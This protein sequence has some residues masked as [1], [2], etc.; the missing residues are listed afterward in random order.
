MSKRRDQL[1]L[2]T[3]PQYCGES[4]RRRIQGVLSRSRKKEKFLL[5]DRGT[6]EQNSCGSHENLLNISL[7]NNSDPHPDQ[8]QT[9]LL[10]KSTS[11]AIDTYRP[12]SPQPKKTL[13]RASF[14]SMNKSQ[15]GS[16]HQQHR[17]CTLNLSGNLPMKMRRHSRHPPRKNLPTLGDKLFQD[18][19][20]FIVEG[21]KGDIRST[22]KHRAIGLPKVSPTLRS[23]WLHKIAGL[24]ITWFPDEACGASNLGCIFSSPA[25]SGCSG[26]SCCASICNA[27]RVFLRLSPRCIR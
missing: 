17:P 5:I 27:R 11:F 8:A 19:R 7:T 9:R 1:Y 15:N 13:P 21:I 12:L 26:S 16:A 4:D 14:C 2:D 23:F 20:V 24:R 22:P 18:I 3:P 6:V 25:A 10:P